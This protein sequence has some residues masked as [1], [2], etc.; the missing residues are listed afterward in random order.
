MERQELVERLR[1]VAAEYED[2]AQ[3]HLEAGRPAV[4]DSCEKERDLLTQAADA[5]S[6]QERLRDELDECRDARFEEGCDECNQREE[7]LRDAL[8]RIGNPESFYDG[9][10][11]EE[12]RLSWMVRIA[13]AALNPP[14]QGEEP[15]E[16]CAKAPGRC[17]RCGMQMLQTVQKATK[18]ATAG[19]RADRSELERPDDTGGG[20]SNSQGERS[21]LSS[22]HTREAEGGGES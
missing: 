13:D 18:S 12:H 16:D 10:D 17:F 7:R 8:E 9:P 1:T 22:S 5:L 2:A 3:A 14:V 6:E 11:D 20:K 4:Q 19:K 21:D 15:C